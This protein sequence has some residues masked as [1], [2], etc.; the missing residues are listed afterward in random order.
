MIR[1][2]PR[3]TRSDTLV[4]YPPLSRAPQTREVLRTRAGGLGIELHVGDDADAA[5]VESY[6][7]LLQYPDTFAAS[8][9][10]A[11]WPRPCTRVADWSRDRKS[12]R[13]NSSH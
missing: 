7:V 9:T 3:S 12:T 11:R 6:G 1:R 4:P 10:T 8:T 5:S 13:L 2:Q